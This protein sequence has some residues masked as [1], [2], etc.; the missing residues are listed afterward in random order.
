MKKDFLTSISYLLSFFLTFF[1]FLP[2]IVILYFI[3]QIFGQKAFIFHFDGYNI[4]YFLFIVSGFM[5]TIYLFPVLDLF[6]NLMEEE[7][8]MGTLEAIFMTPTNLTTII[9]SKYI[10]SLIFTFAITLPILVLGFYILKIKFTGSMILAIT[11]ILVLL[12]ISF[13]AIAMMLASFI[14]IFEKSN[15]IMKIV[16]NIFRIFGEVYFPITILPKSLQLFSYCLPLSYGLRSFRK[17][18]FMGYTF[19]DIIPDATIL[20]IFSIILWPLSFF[21]IRYSLRRAKEKGS[22]LRY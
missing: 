21:T 14:I 7:R 2:L 12:L 11:I 19:M 22:L 8:R 6:Y 13:G 9:I 17:I 15:S 5:I 20:F 16:K 3:I 18:L 1:D 10:W 4:T